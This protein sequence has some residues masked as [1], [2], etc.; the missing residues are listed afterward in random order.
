MAKK[1][2]NISEGK[3]PYWVKPIHQNSGWLLTNLRAG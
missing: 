2:K 3:I 1:I